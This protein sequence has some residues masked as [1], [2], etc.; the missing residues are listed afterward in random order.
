MSKLLKP[1]G[2]YKKLAQGLVDCL[3]G[4]GKAAE[5]KNVM[6]AAGLSKLGMKDRFLRPY[7]RW[8]NKDKIP[9]SYQRWMNKDKIPA[10]YQRWMHK[11]VANYM[12]KEGNTHPD[13][14]DSDEEFT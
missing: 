3:Y 2:D 7:Q 12:D 1:D 5:A 11:R 8:M 13:D 6:K 9:A 10:S 4:Q 14:T